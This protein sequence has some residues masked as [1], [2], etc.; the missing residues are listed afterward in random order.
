VAADERLILKEGSGSRLK[1][2]LKRRKWQQ[3]EDWS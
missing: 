1:F 2:D 3:T